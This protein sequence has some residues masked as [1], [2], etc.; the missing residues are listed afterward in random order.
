[1]KRLV[2]NVLENTYHDKMR[3]GGISKNH[4]MLFHFN[5]TLWPVLFATLQLKGML[6]TDY[7]YDNKT[8]LTAFMLHN[9]NCKG[10]VI[11]ADPV[12]VIMHPILVA[13]LTSWHNESLLT[14]FDVHMG[15]NFSRLSTSLNTASHFLP[16]WS[17]QNCFQFPRWPEEPITRETKSSASTST[18]SPFSPRHV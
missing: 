3:L 2:S 11:G 16:V 9:S 13:C 17:H 12:W 1:M 6:P 10:A 5:R 18:K 8:H 7:D 4:P 14:T 15:S